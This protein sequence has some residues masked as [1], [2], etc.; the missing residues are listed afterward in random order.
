VEPITKCCAEP[1]SYTLAGEDADAEVG[2]LGEAYYQ[3]TCGN[4]LGEFDLQRLADDYIPAIAMATA[5]D[6]TYAA[7][8]KE[9]A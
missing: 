5:L 6:V 2:Y 7:M 1:G 3:C 8:E 4:M 9:T